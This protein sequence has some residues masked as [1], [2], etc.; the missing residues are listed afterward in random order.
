MTGNKISEARL[1]WFGHVLRGQRRMELELPGWR[2]R[3]REE[4]DVLKEGM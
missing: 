3:G 2:R 1:R 4:N